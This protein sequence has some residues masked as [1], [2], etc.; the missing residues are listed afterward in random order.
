MATTDEPTEYQAAMLIAALDDDQHR[1]PAHTD[2]FTVDKLHARRW[3]DGR[4]LTD[5]GRKVARR[6]L[7]GRER[8]AAPA[9]A[10][11]V[12][13]APAAPVPP[14]IDVRQ[15]LHATAALMD[16]DDARC[17]AAY[18]A[19][20]GIPVSFV[21]G[22]IR[23]ATHGPHEVWAKTWAALAANHS[24]TTANAW[25]DDLVALER[26]VFDLLYPQGLH[27]PTLKA[28]EVRAVA[29]Q[30]APVSPPVTLCPRCCESCDAQGY[31]RD[32][33]FDEDTRRWV[34]QDSRCD[35]RG[36]EARLCDDCALVEYA[37]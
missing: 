29:A 2:E 32:A 23:E 30:L 15:A 9:D 10:A 19:P 25:A 17:I 8:P 26:A 21:V 37:L 5:E 3:V 31:I 14:V 6:A 24:V 33:V 27:S 35:C 36:S 16:A 4:A 22:L 11:P 34:P 13:V 28:D 12:T 7:A 1:I 18:G 20:L